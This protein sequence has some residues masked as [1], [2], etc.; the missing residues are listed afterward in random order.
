MATG[1]AHQPLRPIEIQA[2]R[3]ARWKI[4]VL[5]PSFRIVID[6]PDEDQ[7]VVDS[8][9]ANVYL[10]T[11]RDAPS[12]PFGV[13]SEKYGRHI[14]WDSDIW[15]FPTFALTDPDRAAAVSRFRIQTWRDN[16]KGK[17]S[18]FAWET[19]RSG[20]D[21]TQK[22]HDRQ[23][24][25]SGSVAFAIAHASALGL[26]SRDTA[27]QV[28]KSC[29]LFYRRRSKKSETGLFGLLNV[30][31]PDEQR[32]N[33]DND[34]YTNLVAQ[35]CS[36]FSSGRPF[37][38]GQKVYDFP[39]DSETFLTYED[40]SLS[41]YKQAAALL[42]V[43]PLQY[44]ECEREARQLLGRFAGKT[45]PNGPAMSLSVEAIVQARFLDSDI[46][47]QTWRRSWKNYTTEPDYDFH[48]SPQGP[49]YFLTGACGCI[50]TILYGFV[51]LRFNDKPIS[52][53]A[54]SLPLRDG[55]TLTVDPNLPKAWSSIR[56]EGLKVLGQR[57]TL[58]VT[59]TTAEFVPVLHPDDSA[60]IQ[61]NRR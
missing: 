59:R 15:M 44:P 36:D 45:A 55:W 41:G 12:G 60:F 30:V 13:S 6:G 29:D 20:E 35:W 11:S 26:V 43:W 54:S 24:H 23:I 22:P 49:S 51:G 32:D 5:P 39:R 16:S 40:D 33:A 25:V 48:E 56:V 61:G 31:S 58:R 42:S 9:V 14:F 21:L 38:T 7:R 8:L 19:G 53:A 1:C 28:G 10:G 57:Y 47:Y 46:A 52:R 34:L 50:N 37:G 2:V 3:E 27:L 17:F 4:P 18:P